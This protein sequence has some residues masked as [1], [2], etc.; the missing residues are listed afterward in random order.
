MIDRVIKHFPAACVAASLSLVCVPGSA[1]DDL[2]DLDC[3]IEP[4]M[5]VDLASRVDGI[6]ESVEV[7]RGDVIEAEQVL[8]KLDS[9]VERAGVAA[10]R[11]RASASAEIQ[12]N[13][14]S[15][16]FAKRRHDRLQTL[17]L[18]AA[19]S[20][21]QMDEISTEAKL[22]KLQLQ[23]AQENRRIAELE[24]AQSV[25]VLHRHTIRSPIDGVVVQR[26]LSPGESTEDQPIL[27]V[28][29]IDPLRVEVIVPVTAFGAVE[30]GQKA[31][32]Y[33][34]APKEG[35]YAATVSIVDRVADAASGTFRVRLSM[36]NP[37][38]QLPSGLKCR[39]RF[40]PKENVPG[41][42]LVDARSVDQNSNRASG[43]VVPV[44][45]RLTADQAARQCRTV[46]PFTDEAV[47]DRIAE[48]LSGRVRSVTKLVKQRQ[49]ANGFMILSERQASVADAQQLAAQMETAGIA[50]MFVFGKG[51]NAGIVSLGLYTD[52][53]QALERQRFLGDRGFVSEV[54]ARTRRSPEYWLD[55]ELP[56]EPEAIVLASD[57]AL[58]GASVAPV[59]CEKILAARD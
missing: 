35:Q 33:P 26:Y 27:R 45:H 2:G 48:T 58:D 28:A 11:S 4:H 53:L 25:E 49:A 3:V 6:V 57:P 38:Y 18:D 46:G 52:E 41:T 47:A 30:V 1:D 50:D 7:E 23:Q 40:M 43:Q 14:V 12:A 5:V 29:Q 37:D 59:S 55:V 20:G 15:V 9:G 36:P 39:V 42:R 13:N 34:E 8:V 51:A 44:A 32:V 24:L 22:T 19:I 21:D 17:Y 54:T 16:E 10:A 56:A 31:V